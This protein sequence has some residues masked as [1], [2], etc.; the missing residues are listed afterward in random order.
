MSADQ[1][2][3]ILAAAGQGERLAGAN[4]PLPKQFNELG[5]EPLFVWSLSM[6]ANCPEIGKIILVVPKEWQNKAHD[7]L[8]RHLPESMSSV[9]IIAGGSS[10]QES[11]YLALEKL[12]IEN[13]PPLYVLVHDAARPFITADDLKRVITTL[14]KGFACTL[15]I[16][17]FDSIKKVKDALVDQDLDRDALVLMQT[18]QASEFKLMLEAHRHAKQNQSVTTD[19]A[20]IINNFG[21]HVTVLPGSTLNLKIT[22]GAD[23]LIARALIN[24]YQW[25][26]GNVNGI[27]L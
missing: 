4:L 25:R 19:D 3:V 22:D 20:A 15:G 5:G 11:V 16:P 10:R 7:M 17:L 6:L 12:A 8:V 18:P 27:H 13:D 2:A 24:Y 21:T 23:L 1:V 14:K 9:T 26:P